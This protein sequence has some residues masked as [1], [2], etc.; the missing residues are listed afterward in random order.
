MKFGIGLITGY[1]GLVY[2]IPFASPKQL[3]EMVKRAEDLGYDSVW[4]NDHM[5]IQRYVAAKEKVPPNH[6]ESIVT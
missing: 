2:P 1:E 6:Y 4:P 5:T 3:V